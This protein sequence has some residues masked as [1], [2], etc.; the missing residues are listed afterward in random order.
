MAVY[1]AMAVRVGMWQHARCCLPPPCSALSAVSGA[2]RRSAAAAARC[3]HAAPSR[4]QRRERAGRGNAT[5][6]EAMM[7]KASSG[8]DSGARR[9]VFHGRA[10]QRPRPFVS[11]CRVCCPVA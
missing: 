8:E 5:R 4:S 3:R 6:L 9:G 10:A 1:K 11:R 7:L 2:M